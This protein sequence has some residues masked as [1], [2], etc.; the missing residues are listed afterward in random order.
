LTAIH[1]GTPVLFS[2]NGLGDRR[3]TGRI[4]RINPSV[5]PATRQVRIRVSIP[6]SGH[7]LVSGLYAQGRVSTIV[8]V[9]V[10]APA[11]AVDLAG[12]APVVRR[13]HGG[14]VDVLEVQLGVR[15][16]L[17]GRVELIGA[18]AAGDTLLLGS[19]Q[20]L[21][22]GTPVQVML[23]DAGARRQGP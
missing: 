12:S 14:K 9:G 11:A 3:F 6:N 5:D 17:A 19:A 8:K 23:P 7:A 15:D 4:D 2:V 20:A 18:V 22:S 13:L 16:D 1:L 21:S 10:S